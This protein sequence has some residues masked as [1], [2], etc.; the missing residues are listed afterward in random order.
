MTTTKRDKSNLVQHTTPPTPDQ[1]TLP[2][3][4]SISF[5]PQT[6]M[7]SLSPRRRCSTPTVSI[8]SQ[9]QVCVRKLSKDDELQLH[10]PT[11]WM[12]AFA[13]SPP[14]IQHSACAAPAFLSP[15]TAQVAVSPSLKNTTLNTKKELPANSP[16]FSHSPKSPLNV[17]LRKAAAPLRRFSVGNEEH[18]CI[19]S[20]IAAL[21]RSPDTVFVQQQAMHQEYPVVTLSPVAEDTPPAFPETD[22]DD[23][24][25]KNVEFDC[26]F[27]KMDVQSSGSSILTSQLFKSRSGETHS[28]PSSPLIRAMALPRKFS[29]DSGMGQAPSQSGSVRVGRFTVR[30][31]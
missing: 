6:G 24:S 26:T 25:I 28:L 21:M 4:C 10:S 23:A 27:G 31:L 3:A 5:H 13:S 20:A 15:L 8:P 2:P 22:D 29:M 16:V 17:P 18:D 19:S 1:R 11:N 14:S 7:A 12:H 30:R 9:E